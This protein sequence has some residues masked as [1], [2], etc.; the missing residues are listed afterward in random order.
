MKQ[1]K[2]ILSLGLLIMTASVFAQQDPMYTQYITNPITINPAIAGIRNIT[3]LSLVYRNQ[4]VGMEGAPN[5][6]A[7]SYQTLLSQRKVGLAGTM[8]HDRIG[9]VVQ[10]GLYADYAYHLTL[11][12]VK[13]RQLAL[14]LMGGFNYY[15]FD[16]VSLRSSHP[17][18]D[19]PVDGLN[20]RFLPNFGVGAFYHTPSYFLGASLPKLLRNSLSKTDNTL[21][22][23]SREERHLF[24]MTGAII[25][26]NPLFKFR[27]ST[28][29]RMVN[30]APASLDINATIV[31]NE[32]VWLGALYRLGVSWGAMMGWQISKQ[33]YIAYS[34]DFSHKLL[35]G[36]QFGTHEIMLS[37][38]LQFEV[39][40]VI[41]P[42]YF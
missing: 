25:D 28:I 5:T 41:S 22:A 11:D 23:E 34:Y 32:Q 40:R 7:L 20:R 10:T 15:S 35:R 17:D 12:K 39:Q 18:D 21:T 16:I 24:V 26:I 31:Y 8:I 33:M 30:G 3:N 2:F 27:P 38:D 1:L 14:G 13:K 29:G 6:T 37:F 9:P 36:A 4:W 19:I 42:R